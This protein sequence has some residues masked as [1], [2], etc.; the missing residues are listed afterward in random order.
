MADIVCPR[1]AA[2]RTAAIT[3]VEIVVSASLE[4]FGCT[5]RV[6]N[7]VRPRFAQA[8][9]PCQKRGEV[10]SIKQR[11]LTEFD[12]F[13]VTPFDRC[14]ERSS[15]D[16]EQV[17]C[18]ADRVRGLQ[19]RTHGGQSDRRTCPCRSASN[20]VRVIFSGEPW[21]HCAMRGGW[22]E[23]PESALHYAVSSFQH[24][25]VGATSRMAP[26]GIFCTV[27]DQHHGHH[28][29]GEGQACGGAS[30]YH[31]LAPYDAQKP[32]C[33]RSWFRILTFV[34]FECI[35]RVACGA[36]KPL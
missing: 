7:A 35:N 33:G 29:R 2:D 19:D 12:T 21:P 8:P 6:T 14:V 22:N 3:T 16:T 11:L 28:R 13:E 9:E 27:A 15:T 23:R 18:L 26:T 31:V 34:N 17:K 5:R 36:I 32:L 10:G 24:P 25:D 4:V 20:P 1:S 30:R